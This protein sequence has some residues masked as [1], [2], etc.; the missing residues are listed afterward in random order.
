MKL[1][2]LSK[3][4]LAAGLLAMVAC[5][6]D[7]PITSGD[8]NATGSG[9]DGDG[10]YMSLEVQ[11]PTDGS[12]SQTTD[13]G[14][15]QSTD[16]TEVGLDFENTVNEVIIVLASSVDNSFITA[17]TVASSKLNPVPSLNAYRP[18][19]KLEKT[20]ISDFYAKNENHTLVNV[21]V[22]CNPTKDLTDVINDAS[23]GDTGWYD[24][25]C[26]VLEGN[27]H[28]EKN[29]GIWKNDAFLMS[30]SE[31]CTR[32]LP[33]N[34]DEWKKYNTESSA[35]DLSGINAAG[36][37]GEVDNSAATKGRG[38]VKVERN[39]ARFDFRDGSTLGNNTYNVI[40]TLDAEGKQVP[41]I[42]VHLNRMLLANEAKEFYYLPRVSANG[43]LTNSILCGSETKTNYV[44]GPNASVFSKSLPAASY[45]TYFNYPFFDA[46]GENDYRLWHGALINDVLQVN[47]EKPDNLDNLKQD[48]HIWRYV[49]E[50]VI[51]ASNDN[52]T[53][54]RTTMVVFKGRMVPDAAAFTST[55]K[56]TKAM[57]EAIGNGTDEHPGT[58]TGISTDDPVIYYCNNTVYF[59][60]DNIKQAAIESALQFDAKGVP[61][62]DKDKDGNLHP[63]GVRRSSSLYLAVFGDGSMGEFTWGE[64][65]YYDTPEDLSIDATSTNALYDTYEAN[66]TDENRAAFKAAVVAQNITIYESSNDSEDG[67]G[68]YFYYY[69]KNRHNDNRDSTM[70]TMEFATVRNNVY[71]LAVTKIGSLGHPRIPENDPDK[72]TPDT[73]DE[74]DDINITVT[75]RVLPWVVRVNNIEF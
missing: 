69:Y 24:T 66:K 71:K 10:Y 49:T 40:Y 59:G 13:E 47:N 9:N 45:S 23:L 20:N 46:N 6:D 57:A 11:L 53:M 42:N 65:T 12:R 67:P 44:V 19:A 43:Q 21:F 25:T 28:S 16:G 17:G 30:N 22:F 35:F 34:I 39:V 3:S 29:L 4:L 27:N 72:P 51:P 58:L 56:Y 48:Y 63:T 73:P 8:H 1:N 60:W 61:T 62:A 41:L 74:S 33:A 75:C 70:G 2:I 5:S 31:I 68:Y 64:T 36:Q 50:N 18:I 7:A 52:Q 37:D 54:S 38:T 15:G 26:T 32:E 14:W 55:D